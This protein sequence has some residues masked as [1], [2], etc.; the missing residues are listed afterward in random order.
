MQFWNS[1]PAV[2][3]VDFFFQADIQVFYPV[4]DLFFTLS[5]PCIISAEVFAEQV[6]LH[7]LLV[8]FPY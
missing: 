1:S 4:A 6:A 5:F 7:V 3:T 2:Y 8:D